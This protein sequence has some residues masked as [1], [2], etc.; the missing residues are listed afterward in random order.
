MSGRR[1]I[2]VL[3]HGETTY[4]AQR[5]WQGQLDVPLSDRGLEQAAGA[6]VALK[7]YG[8]SRVVA[9]DLSRAALTG[10]R[11]AESCGVEIAYDPRWREIDAGAWQG[12]VHAEVVEQFGEAYAALERG[13]DVRRGGTGETLADVGARV[14][15]AGR[16]LADG[17]AEGECVVVASHGVAGRA[18]VAALLG[19]DQRVAWDLLGGLGNCH[20][21]ELEQARTGWRLVRWN[22]V[23]AD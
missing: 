15:A 6:G 14:A 17:M 8:P 19:L 23:S 7:A 4:N 12:L 2:I 22:A 11:V 9:S 3:R 10:E 18:G 1:R 21:G 5:R 20:W 16:E 13:E